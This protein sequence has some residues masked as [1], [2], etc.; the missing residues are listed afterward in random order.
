MFWSLAQAPRGYIIAWKCC[1]ILPVN[2]RQTITG[3]PFLSLND[4]KM[5]TPEIIQVLSGLCFMFPGFALNQPAGFRAAITNC[6][7]V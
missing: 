4:F 7:A 5:V 2:G 3:R 6:L 1:A